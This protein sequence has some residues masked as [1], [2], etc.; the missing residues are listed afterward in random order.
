VRIGGIIDDLAEAVNYLFHHTTLNDDQLA[1][2]IIS[3]YHLQTTGRQVKLQIQR[4]TP[5]LGGDPPGWMPQCPQ[6][7]P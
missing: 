4:T 6:C 1:A 3:D 7:R 2:R 5:N